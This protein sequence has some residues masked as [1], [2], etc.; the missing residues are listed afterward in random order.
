MRDAIFLSWGYARYMIYTTPFGK[1]V[2][3]VTQFIM[4][5]WKTSRSLG[6]KTALQ[7]RFSLNLHPYQTVPQCD[8]IKTLT[9]IPKLVKVNSPWFQLWENIWP[10][11]GISRCKTVSLLTKNLWF[12][13]PVV[14]MMPTGRF[15]VELNRNWNSFVLLH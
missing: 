5:S 11:L 1:V 14:E 12:D 2:K 13:N 6:A 4:C 7:N 9:V 3:Y 10:L 15:L 8:D